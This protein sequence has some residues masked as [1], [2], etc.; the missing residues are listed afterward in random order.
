[1]E[2]SHGQLKIELHEG[3]RQAV[4]HHRAVA[5]TDRARGA[6]GEFDVVRDHDQRRACLGIEVEDEFDDALARLGVEVAGRLVGEEDRGTVD[7]RPCER[8]ALLLAAGELRGVVA[9]A[10]LQADLAEEVGRL[11]GQRAARACG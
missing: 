11:R 2:S 9:A 1:M 4:V 7:E 3:R 10:F 5:Q 6:G 8:N